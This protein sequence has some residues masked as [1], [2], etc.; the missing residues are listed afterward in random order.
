ML[1][2]VLEPEEMDTPEE[3]NEYDAM[4]HREVNRR[5]VADFLAA[6]GPCRGGMIL[7][8]GT[9]TARI[10]IELCR[11]DAQARVVAMDLAFSMIELAR[12]NVREAGLE[13]RITPYWGDAKEAVGGPFEAVISNSIVHHIPDPAKALGT[14]AQAVSPGATLFVRDLARP[15]SRAELQALVDRYA[16]GES[17]SA[18][19]MFAA[20]LHAALR[21]DEVRA[22]VRD[23]GWDEND[24]RM[25]SDRHWTWAARRP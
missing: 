19:G 18:R 12:R 7:D 9:G 16:A 4:D 3:A 11:N 2:R 25:T 23:L 17:E 21:V 8:V 10:P 24:V 5:F 6:Q 14:M 1:P 13:G 22:L 20:S 15:D